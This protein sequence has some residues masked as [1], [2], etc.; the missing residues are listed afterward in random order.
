[1]PSP[2]LKIMTIL[3]YSLDGVKELNFLFITT[4]AIG[5]FYY[6]QYL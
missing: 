4:L 5:K 1:M 6:K 2:V 3:S